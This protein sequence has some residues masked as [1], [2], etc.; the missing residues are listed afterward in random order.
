MN[1]GEIC[2]REVTVMDRAESVRAAVSLMRENHVGDIVV[3]EI[4]DGKRVPVGILTDRDVLIEVIA[5]GVS[6]D[7][8]AVGDVMSFDL[9]AVRD[10][11]AELHAL[12]Q[13]RSKGVRRAPVVDADGVLVGIVSIDDLLEVVAEELSHIAALIRREQR[14]ESSTR[15]A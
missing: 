3:T 1:V 11:V 7:D 15:N 6:P 5:K 13:M 10:E 2:T 14:Q 9:L 12:E 8:L 4:R